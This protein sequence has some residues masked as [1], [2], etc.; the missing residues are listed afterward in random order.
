MDTLRNIDTYE[1]DDSKP[2]V[3]QCL[4]WN[5]D[6]EFVEDEESSTDKRTLFNFEHIVKIYGVD[7]EGHSVSLR[8][9]KFQPYFYIKVP[10][11]ADKSL[12]MKVIQELKESGRIKPFIATGILSAEFVERKEFYGFT[13]QTNF[14]FIKLSFQNLISMRQSEYMLR[15]DGIKI[16][17]EI[18]KFPIYESNILPFIRFMHEK[19]LDSAGWITIPAGK[20]DVNDPKKSNCQIDVEAYWDNVSFKQCK[21]LA[22]FLVASFDIECNSSHGDFPLAKK[23]YKKMANEVYDNYIKIIDVKS[24]RTT[25]DADKRYLI[26]ELIGIAFSIDTS[27]ISPKYAVKHLLDVSKV[28][29][30]NNEKPSIDMYDV[31]AKKLYTILER[32]ETYKILALDI[33]CHLDSDILDYTSERQIKSKV[34][35]IIYDAFSDNRENNNYGKS[36]QTIFTK[37]N[38]KPNKREILEVGASVAKIIKLFFRKVKM[39]ID[40]EDEDINSI[41]SIFCKNEYISRDKINVKIQKYYEIDDADCTILMT[42]IQQ[43][44]N[45]VFSI[46]DERFPIVDNSRSTYCNRITEIFDSAFPK[47]NGDK[48]VQIGTTVQRFGETGCFLK[49]IITLN[50][51][52]DIDGV[53]VESYDSEEEVLLAWTRF[54][55]ELDPDIITGYNIFGFDFSFMWVRAEELGI[56]DAF[57]LLGRERYQPKG[58]DGKR[59]K[60]WVSKPSTLELKT[61]SSSAL[62]DNVLKYIS[63]EGR[64]VMDLLKIVQKDFNLASY[65]LDT[66][67]ETFINDKITNIV[68]NKLTVNGI[69]NL[70]K[71][72]YI[73]INYGKDSK[74]KDKK[75][76][77]RGVDYDTN[78]IELEEDVD[79]AILKQKPKWTLAKDDVTPQDIF[80]LQDGSDDDRKTVAVYCIQDCALCITLIDKLKLITNNIGMANVC[81]VPISFLFLRGQGIKIFS[82]VAKECRDA[83]YLIPV[84]K[85]TVEEHS[86]SRVAIGQQNR[87]IF[88]YGEDDTLPPPENLG[89]YEGAIVLKPQPGIYINKPIAVLDYSSLYPSSMISENL[90]HDSI[91][92]DIPENKKYLGDEG[93]KELEKLGYGIVDITYDV[94]EWINIKIKSKGKK[95]TGVKTCRFVQPEDGSK[96]IIP[97]ILRKLLS[98]RKSTRKLIKFETIMTI[99]GDNISHEFSGLVQDISGSD[100]ELRIVD[101]DGNNHTIL[102][103]EIV[104]RK[105]TYSEFEQSVF[106]GLQTAYK[107]TAN[108]LY[109]Q[110]GAQTSPIY[111]K[112]IAAATTATGRKLLYLAKEKVEDKFE[113]AKIVYGDT[114][115]IFINFNPPS[116]GREGLKESID[117]GLQAEEYIQQFLKPPHKLEYEKTFWPFILFSKKRYIGN[118]YEFKTGEN[119]YKQTSMGIVL[120]RRDNAEIVKHIYGGVIDILINKQNVD[121]SITFLKNELIKLL[122]GQ[123][124]MDMLVVTK[125]L[126]GFYKN[127]EQIAHKVLADRIGIRDPGNKPSSND[128]IPYVYIETKD[129][130]KLQGDRIETP[131]YIKEHTLNPDYMFY[132]TNQIMKPVAQIYSLIVEDLKGFKYGEHYYENKYKSLLSTKTPEKAAAKI[133]DIKFKD[134]CDIIFADVIRQADNKKNKARLITDFFG[135]RD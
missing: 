116:K 104:S 41:L 119:D 133:D 131:D 71:N 56:V 45:Q 76:K 72:N 123:F 77:I 38:K 43:S 9:N 87:P 84:I 34:V 61:L 96:S 92:L 52:T 44:M 85:H 115:S 101:K 97:N 93:E 135:K 25:S 57:S 30:E 11:D 63:M 21:K 35:K 83:G 17:K 117:M 94:Y 23:N 69:I 27:L 67:A 7:E 98:A 6:N 129:K 32:Q 130:P 64:I 114:D 51:C 66:V 46:F 49:H 125:S 128:R 8:V 58:V 5:S 120:K 100:E 89:G 4:H 107:L 113:G 26:K 111:L 70:A 37:T 99:D 80:R 19:K 78:S 106:D 68:G 86:I 10:I 3:M 62:G 1:I 29:T 28:Y 109:G 108:S 48:V 90:S 18:V 112:D 79:T 53:E 110:L 16:G 132:I 39:I 47:I 24:K 126:R 124:P 2:L 31:V 122:D 102:K 60:E 134:T 40:I 95:K 50:G 33:L 36:I 15:E 14:K 75:W 103:A 81:S 82:L 13:N 127:P 74:Y 12:K 65:K 54:I 42:H 91:V 118:K 59:Q 105:S 88:D 73:T 20:Y 55:Q 22:P 121:L